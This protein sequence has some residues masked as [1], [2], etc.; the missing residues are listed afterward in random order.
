MKLNLK[1][2]ASNMNTIDAYQLGSKPREPSNNSR[3][4]TIKLKI[5][6]RPES[7]G[8]AESETTIVQ[9]LTDDVVAIPNN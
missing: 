7:Q 6:K 2:P 4:K 8:P 1:E 5:K 9:S 3:F